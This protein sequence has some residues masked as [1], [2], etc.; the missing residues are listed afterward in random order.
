MSAMPP[1]ARA[2]VA[3][4]LSAA[5][6]G[7]RLRDSGSYRR[8]RDQFIACAAEECPG[9]VRKGCV[10]WLAELEKLMPTVVFAARSQGQEV[11]DVR[12]SADGEPVAERIDGKPVALDPGEHHFRFERTGEE[13]VEEAAVV[14]AGEKQ[15]RVTARFG[16]EPI[17]TPPSA[18]VPPQGATPVD[19]SL[20]AHRAPGAAAYALGAFGLVSLATGLALDV[21]GFVFIQQCGGDRSCT[22]AH[23]IAEVQWRLVTGD[24]LLVAGALSAVAAWLLWQRDSYPVPQRPGTSVAA[25]RGGTRTPW[26]IIR[27]SAVSFSF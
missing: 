23:E 13:S 11:T 17:P 7:Q 22:R 14:V 6:A 1:S 26:A 18:P 21:S 25:N 8:A 9:E 12:V 2:D 24:V 15:R 16:P 19:A 5:E 27:S 10:G 20:R 3:A 4:C